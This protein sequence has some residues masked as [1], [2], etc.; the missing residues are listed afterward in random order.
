MFEVWL[1]IS[2][3]SCCW[4]A[5]SG[6]SSSTA[7]FAGLR[8]VLFAVGGEGATVRVMLSLLFAV[9]VAG[10]TSGDIC[11]GGVAACIGGA[12]ACRW[13]ARE[14]RL[15]LRGGTADVE[16][17][18]GAREARRVVARDLKFGAGADMAGIG[19]A[20]ISIEGGVEI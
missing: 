13:G 2:S 3:V 7:G 11:I 20:E 6:I 15:R 10:D 19:P 16:P 18:P 17:A 1:K 8:A 4:R 9:F 5:S 14:A 12:A